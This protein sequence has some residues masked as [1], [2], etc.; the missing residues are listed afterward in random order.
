MYP[1]FTT[2][3]TLTAQEQGLL[4]RAVRAQGSRRDRAILSLALGTGLRLR[5]IAG[6]NVGDVS[7]EGSAIAWKVLTQRFARHSSPLSGPITFTFPPLP[8]PP[9]PDPD[10]PRSHGR[11]EAPPRSL[12][13]MAAYR[14][15]P[16]VA[17]TGSRPER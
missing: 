9:E 3:K 16:I 5:E 10:R 1:K 6:L 15:D 4:L 7:T 8:P 14:A 11:S 2:P 17:N 12:Q 13:C